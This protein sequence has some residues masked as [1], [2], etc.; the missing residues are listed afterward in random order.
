MQRILKDMTSRL[1]WADTIEIVRRWGGRTLDVPAA[2]READP[3]ALTLGLAS[4]Q[5]LVQHYAGQRL[6]LP[7]EK[8][9]LIDSRDQRIL[10]E[11][12]AGKSEESVGLMFG[13]TRQGVAAVRRKVEERAA[14]ATP[15]V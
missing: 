4:A 5:R 10:A 15:C 1:G 8:R 14:P 3:L 2:V 13:L 11:L 7:S 6:Q 9:A 12:A